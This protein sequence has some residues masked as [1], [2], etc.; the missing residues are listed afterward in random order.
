MAL[1]PLVGLYNPALGSRKTTLA[2]AMMGLGRQTKKFVGG[3]KAMARTLPEYAGEPE[4]AVEAMVE[5]SRTAS[6]LLGCTPRHS[7]QTLGTEFGRSCIGGDFW[8]SLFLQ[9]ALPLRE[10][11]T[12]AVCDD[13]RFPN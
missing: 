10:A 13:T 7:L 2:R 12:P 1:P 4:D 11:G 9:P 5:G 6:V 3:I 8:V